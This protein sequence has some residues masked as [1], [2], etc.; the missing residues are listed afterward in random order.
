[1]SNISFDS[2]V[3]SGEGIVEFG[4]GVNGQAK[5]SQLKRRIVKESMDV[6][7]KPGRPRK[8]ADKL[9]PI[10]GYVPQEVRARIEALT[11][12]LGEWVREACIA[13]LS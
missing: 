6:K 9:V 10:T 1:M 5:S 13:K 3:A 11:N 2:A 12:N 4:D 7:R 8:H